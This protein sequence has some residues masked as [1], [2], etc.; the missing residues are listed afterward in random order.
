MAEQ[1]LSQR[2]SAPA[3]PRSGILSRA[4]LVLGNVPLV[5]DVWLSRRL[6]RP[7]RYLP[8]LL[9]FVTDK[10]NLRCSMCG[11][12]QHAEPGKD[13][14]ELTTEEWKAVIRSAVK[15]RTIL[16][17][18]TG[19][20]AILRPDVFEIIRYARENGISVHLCSNGTVLNN[21]NVDRLRESGVNTVSISI[22]NMVPEVHERLR[23]G[24]SFD[25]AIRGIRLLRERAPEIRVGINYLIT[26]QNF[27]NMA[28]MIPFA[29]SLGVHQI[30][31]APIH[32]NLQHKGKRLEE[33]AP[34]I[35]T[36]KDLDE[37]EA[38]IEKLAEAAG[39]SRLQT[40]SR[41]FLDG[42]V[43]LYRHPRTGFRCYA[44]YAACA[45]N[46][47]GIVTPCC[48][49]EGAISVRD[50]PLDEIWRSSEFQQ[51]RRSVHTCDKPCWDT[52]NAEL[53]LRFGLRGMLG[54]IGQTWRDL[55]FYF[56]SGEA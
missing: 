17:S 21:D 44:G 30:K 2:S 47:R 25:R 53:S 49:M 55:K 5:A 32:T 3:K 31:F 15:L 51:L 40:T 35:F 23:G 52:T 4:K 46:P 20:E 12:W 56:G 22:E 10:C 13:N 48:D 1:V 6:H 26:A 7:T 29:E 36:E 39:K 8:I 37:L 18:I 11:V 42:I 24:G 34:L 9:L 50:K 41:T 28:E 38:E 16:L 33:F 54:E 19:G 27:R 14:G 43:S 45:I